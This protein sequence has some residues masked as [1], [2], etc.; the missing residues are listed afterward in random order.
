MKTKRIFSSATLLIICLSGT[1]AFAGDI[2]AGKSKS[3]TCSSCHGGN[4]ISSMDMWP[5][6]AGQKTAYLAK[7]MRAFRDGS[8]NDTVMGSMAKPLSDTDI[9]DLAAYYAS[10]PDGSK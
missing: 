7:Q 6:L 10:L 9:E 2:A 4:G 8:R 1:T 3:A 5:N